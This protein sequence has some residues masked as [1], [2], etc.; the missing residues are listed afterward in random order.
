[1]AKNWSSLVKSASKEL[2]RQSD[3]WQVELYLAIIRVADSLDAMVYKK[4]SNS[5]TNRANLGLLYHLIA[6][7]GEM[8]QTEL[9]RAASR[10]KQAVG[11]SLR[12]QE[13]RGLVARRRL[14]GDQRV[15]MVSITRKGLNLA[16]EI[17]P[18][19]EEMLVNVISCLEKSGA[20]KM[21]DNLY[22][23]RDKVLSEINDF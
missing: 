6:N 23:L 2:S 11:L 8:R 10:T 19:R 3:L 15:K 5:G 1:M 17:L 14:P 12:N 18:L 21:V 13:K 9:A 20:K 22:R 16:M 4:F 7:G